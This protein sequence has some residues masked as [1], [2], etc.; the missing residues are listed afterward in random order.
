LKTEGFPADA[1]ARRSRAIVEIAGRITCWLSTDN[2][3]KYLSSQTLMSI[4]PNQYGGAPKT[5]TDYSDSHR[6]FFKF[7]IIKSNNLRNL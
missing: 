7:L 3:H 6:L 4:K 5:T 1:I 2:R